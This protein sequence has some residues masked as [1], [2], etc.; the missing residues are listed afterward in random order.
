M[1]LS[2]IDHPDTTVVLAIRGD[3][4]LDAAPALHT[5]LE[6]VLSR[7]RP[8]VV[9]DLSGVEFCDSIGLSAFVLGAHRADR[10][11]G[12]LRLAAPSPWLQQLLTRVGLT[13]SLEIFPD[14]PAAMAA[15]DSPAATA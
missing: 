4:D 8:R 11:D 14:V 12:W 13:R 3:L 15:G 5:A 9:I 6:E 1:E 7:P 10:H 2:L